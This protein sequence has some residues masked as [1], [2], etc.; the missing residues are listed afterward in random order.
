MKRILLSLL[1]ALCVATTLHAGEVG[2]KTTVATTDGSVQARAR[3]VILVFS[4]DFAGTVN[5]VSYTFAAGGSFNFG[6]F[7]LNDLGTITY[8]ISSGTLR[9][10][11]L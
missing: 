5:G 8:T 11:R 6:P 4:S 3:Q 1:A 9:I 10:V 2:L 7:D